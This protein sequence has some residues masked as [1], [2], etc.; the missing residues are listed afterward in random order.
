MIHFLRHNV[1][2]IRIFKTIWRNGQTKCHKYEDEVSCFCIQQFQ[3]F[4]KSFKNLRIYQFHLKTNMYKY[5]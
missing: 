4:M 1:K 5:A 2:I 3:I